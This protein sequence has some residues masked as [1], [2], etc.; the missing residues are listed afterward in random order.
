MKTESE[1]LLYQ[2]REKLN[3]LVDE[4]LQKVTPIN[5]TH[6]IEEQFRKVKRMTS[7]AL[8]SEAVLAQ[9]LRVDRLVVMVEREKEKEG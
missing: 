2:G 5:E 9:S 3:R 6:E 1:K 8:Q 7:E 4:A